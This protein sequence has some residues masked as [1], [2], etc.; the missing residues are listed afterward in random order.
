MSTSGSLS[1]S[2]GA[3]VVSALIAAGVEHI[4]LAPGSR[5]APLAL[6]AARA[7]R[8][9]RVRLHVRIDERSAAYLALGIAKGSGVPV[10]VI[11]TSG[12][13]AVNLHPAIVEASYGGV[14]L[15]AVTA[16]RPPRL[17]GVGANQT[18]EQAG[19]FGEMPRFA[20]D[21]TVDLTV[22]GDIDPA[23]VIRADT[24]AIAE[25]VRCATDSQHP[26]PAHVNIALDEP[27]VSTDSSMSTEVA[28]PAESAIPGRGTA[29]GADRRIDG[30]SASARG[31]VVV[32]DTA[33]FPPEAAAPEL[34]ES[35]AERTGWPIISEPSGNASRLG[36]ALRHGPLVV[37]DAAF[38]ADHA[39]DIVVTIGRVG[40]HR[41][42]MRMIARAD[43]HWVV[44]PRP[45]GYACDP[46][47]TARAILP[48]LPQVTVRTDPDWGNAWQERDET[49]ARRVQS[50]WPA[51][52]EEPLDGVSIARSVVAALTED[53][54]LVVGPSWP[55]RH[56]SAYSGPIAGTVFANRGTS[57][58]DG[59]V[60]SSWGIALT[61]TGF[62]L[63]LLG[64]LTA[65][66]D[67]NGL[68]A[69]P[70]EPLPHLA[71]VVIDNDGGGIFGEL[72]QGRAEFAEDFERVFGTPH[73]GDLAELLSAPGVP[74]HRVDR[75]AQLHAALEQARSTRG[76]SIIIATT[77]P[78]PDQVVRLRGLPDPAG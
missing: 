33:G 6:A 75:L 53:D 10:A 14:P 24:A 45:T 23:Q 31:V 59:I 29:S 1:M 13:A 71:Y 9:G 30:D 56:V 3:A 72:E 64:D 4:V 77:V 70:G 43:E 26:G 5:S 22:E 37:D 11:T 68:L 58:I 65:L 36:H 55:V 47:R 7:E 74:I 46:M 2:R 62:T 61:R 78:R 49:F 19:L 32:G 41:G 17:R 21:L 73:G 15:I 76:V 16:D 27:L 48:S 42:V 12:T 54:T 8:E 57:G 20:V 50:A 52:S 39:P 25:A 34:I 66:Y 38:L 18:I 28:E 69:A 51:A 35:L 67:R 44:D 40:L 60:S 63:A